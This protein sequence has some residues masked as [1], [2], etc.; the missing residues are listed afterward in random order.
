MNPYVKTRQS[1]FY[2]RAVGIFNYI[3][4]TAQ[5]SS[6]SPQ[7]KKGAGIVLGLSAAGCLAIYQSFL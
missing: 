4:L 6:L 7:A 5:K 2:R 1:A 3:K